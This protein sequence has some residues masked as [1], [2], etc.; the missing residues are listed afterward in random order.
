MKDSLILDRKIE[1]GDKFGLM[2]VL[3]V[4]LVNMLIPTATFAS[5][6][7][8]FTQD[9]EVASQFFLKS[10]TQTDILTIKMAEAKGRYLDFSNLKNKTNYKEKLKPNQMY[11]TS[12]AYSS[13]PAQTDD[14]PCITA[15]GFD[16]CENNIENVVAANFL[17][18]GTKVKIPDLFGDRIFTVQDRMNTKYN[19]RMDLWMTSKTRAKT[20]GIRY[21]KIE[22]VKDE[23]TEVAMKTN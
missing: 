5:S 6:K 8:V 15:N 17:K 20:Y 14:T 23:K 7:P 16:V 13:E 18:F 10:A 3:V 12:T 9:G 11:V 1:L 19:K 22:I 21:V 4:F 2:V